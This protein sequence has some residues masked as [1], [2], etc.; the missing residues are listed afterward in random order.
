[1]SF[2]PRKCSLVW[3]TSKHRGGHNPVLHSRPQFCPRFLVFGGHPRHRTLLHCIRQ[4]LLWLD[5]VSLSSLFC[6]QNAKWD[7][8][9]TDMAWLC[10]DHCKPVN[11]RCSSWT[12]CIVSPLRG[13][14]QCHSGQKCLSVAI[15]DV[16]VPFQYLCVTSRSHVVLLIAILLNSLRRNSAFKWPNT[17]WLCNSSDIIF[18]PIA[19]IALRLQLKIDTRM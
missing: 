1:M 18:W 9:C 17:F 6:G 2:D 7:R 13:L 19:F 11:C 4:C 15:N 12:V 14:C 5:W 16:F 3:Y 8:V 10:W